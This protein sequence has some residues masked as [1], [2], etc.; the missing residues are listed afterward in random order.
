MVYKKPRTHGRGRR[1]KKRV[2]KFPVRRPPGI[3]AVRASG[4]SIY[5]SSTGAV[6]AGSAQPYS[7]AFGGP[8]I[9]VQ[10]GRLPFSNVG[11][12]RLPYSESFP[13]T[14][15]GTT[16]LTNTGYT[17]RLNSVYDPRVELGGGQPMQF[18]YLVG[19]FLN[20]RYWVKGVK[21]TVTF[22]NPDQDGM[23]VGFRIRASTNGTTSIGKSIAEVKEMDLTRSRWIH[24]T[25]NQTTSFS[26]YIKPWNVFGITREQYNNFEYSAGVS[27]NPDQIVLLEP[28]AL[29]SVSGQEATI[30]CTVS[31]RYYI[32]LTNRT[33]VLD[34]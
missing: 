23:L 14:A 28:F 32:Q 30:R 15:D 26:H 4:Q 16:G 20:G 34:V 29:H 6:R 5:R 31:I 12:Y 3:Y 1:G 25:G 18:D 22:S 17:Y 8:S 24:N 10:Q 7:V 21:F 9:N 13:I 33:T 2:F 19:P 27:A 11:I